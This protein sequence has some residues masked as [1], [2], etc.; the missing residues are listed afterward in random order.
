MSA[1]KDYLMDRADGYS[2]EEA[3][4]RNCRHKRTIPTG[5]DEIIAAQNE[6]IS[7]LK[8]VSANSKKVIHKQEDIIKMLKDQ[9]TQLETELYAALDGHLPSCN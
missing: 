1:Y 7:E 2:R 4:A 9:I 3:M 6:L 5:Q 8:Q